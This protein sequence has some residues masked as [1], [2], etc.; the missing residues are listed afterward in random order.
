[1]KIPIPPTP[2][3]VTL[4]EQLTELLGQTLR[5]TSLEWTTSVGWPAL[6]WG[7]TML[8]GKGG[9]HTGALAAPEGK[10]ARSRPRPRA[11]RGTIR[12]PWLLSRPEGAAGHLPRPGR[13]QR[14]RWDRR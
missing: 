11:H 4:L 1:M 2:A 14:R 3:A 5:F 10:T 12:R 7:Q 8:I 9:C 6:S 13:R